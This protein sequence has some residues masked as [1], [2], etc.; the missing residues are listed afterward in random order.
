MGIQIFKVITDCFK[1]TQEYLKELQITLNKR[2]TSL[3]TAVSTILLN[4]IKTQ[5]IN[6]E[7]K[8]PITFLRTDL[9]KGSRLYLSRDQI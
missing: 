3:F 8:S 7:R 1:Q 6:T 2:G 9:L 5:N 4:E